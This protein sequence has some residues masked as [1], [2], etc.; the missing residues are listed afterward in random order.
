MVIFHSYSGFTHWK[1]WFSIV[2]VDLPIDSMVIFQFVMLARLPEGIWYG[3]LWKYVTSKSIGESSSAL[4]MAYGD[5]RI[6]LGSWVLFVAHDQSDWYD[7]SV[8]VLYVFTG[9]W[10][11]FIPK[12]GWR[13]I[14]MASRLDIISECIVPMSILWPFLPELDVQHLTSL[15]SKYSTTMETGH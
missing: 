9:A 15:V 11:C 2:I 3:F 12:L 6:I 8:D 13:L 5:G 1:W 14:S 4:F 7:L 10:R